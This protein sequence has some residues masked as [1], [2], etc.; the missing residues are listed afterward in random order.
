MSSSCYIWNITNDSETETRNPLCPSDN[1]F[2]LDFYNKTSIFDVITKSN[3]SVELGE[4]FYTLDACI[5]PLGCYNINQQ[6]RHEVSNSIEPVSD[7]FNISYSASS[8]LRTRQDQCDA[9]E[10]CGR[11][12][13]ST[14]HH[15]KF[16]NH[17]AQLAVPDLSV[18]NDPSSSAHEALCWIMTRDP[19]LDHFEICDGT[20][21]QRYVLAL[22][23]L[24][25]SSNSIS[26]NSF[27]SN[28]T[29]DW[30]GIKCDASNKFIEHINL[31]NHDLTGTLITEIGLLTRLQTI[32]FNRNK[33]SGTID[34][35]MFHHLPDLVKFDAGDNELRGKIPKQLFELPQLKS[36]DVSNNKFIGTLPHDIV[37][38][39]TLGK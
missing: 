3:F 13:D 18:L 37:Y 10:V 20:L 32:N 6:L 15:R 31:F 22:F 11:P 1:I 29:C 33:L 7:A 2:R 14:H 39:K 27:S 23:Y 26:F 5:S 4:D 25:L 21:L 28:H 35:I 38:A 8:N 16:L 30:I 17:I 19:I 36:V 12:F 34:P 9:V 24:S